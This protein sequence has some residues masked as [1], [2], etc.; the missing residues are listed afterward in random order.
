MCGEV[1]SIGNFS[2]VEISEQSDTQLM[3]GVKVIKLQ[4]LERFFWIPSD[5]ADTDG[6]CRH[7]CKF[8]VFI[9]H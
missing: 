7:I 2:D 1:C 4:N 6:P 9:L 3:D 8:C 5:S